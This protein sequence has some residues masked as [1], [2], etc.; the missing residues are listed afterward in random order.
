MQCPSTVNINGA[1]AVD[2]PAMLATLG[3]YDNV[4]GPRHSQTLT[5][6]AHIAE[7]VLGLGQTQ[8]ARTLLERVV[9]D[10]NRTHATRISALRTLR[11]LCIEQADTAKAAAVQNEISE[12]WM[13]LAGSDAPETVAARA[14]LEALLMISAE[15]AFAA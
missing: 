8:A 1:D 2:L 3:S 4:F 14:D 5:L 15:N 13:L 9:R 12:C 7:V 10:L 11:D 6:A